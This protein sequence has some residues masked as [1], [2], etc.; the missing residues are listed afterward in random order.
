MTP[1]GLWRTL[2]LPVQRPDQQVPPD[3]AN[4][5]GVGISAIFCAQ[6]VAQSSQQVIERLQLRAFFADRKS[7]AR[8]TDELDP[9]RRGRFWSAIEPGAQVFATGTAV[10]EISSRGWQIVRVARG[11]LSPESAT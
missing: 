11:V 3:R 5:L 7:G 4:V 2:P 9:E 1:R 6:G 8:K 10:P